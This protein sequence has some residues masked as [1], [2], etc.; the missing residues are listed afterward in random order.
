MAYAPAAAAAAAAAVAAKT[1]YATEA[2]FRCE[3]CLFLQKSNKVFVL[4]FPCFTNGKSKPYVWYSFCFLHT[5]FYRRPKSIV[6]VYMPNRANGCCQDNRRG[7][8]SS[9]LDVRAGPCPTK[10]SMHQTEELQAQNVRCNQHGTPR[11]NHIQSLNV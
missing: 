2:T 7:L 3:A 5:P 6:H 10:Q 4:F 1:S 9:V 8:Q 11:S